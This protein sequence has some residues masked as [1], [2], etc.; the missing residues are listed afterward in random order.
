MFYFWKV[1]ELKYVLGAEHSF[2]AISQEAEE[3]SF[4]EVWFV[5]SE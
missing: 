2:S 5:V 1:V 4:G 3:I